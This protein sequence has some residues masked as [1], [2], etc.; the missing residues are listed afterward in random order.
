MVRV[1]IID[2][3][4]T[5]TETDR[6]GES[7]HANDFSQKIS[8]DTDVYIRIPD[9]KPKLLFSYRRK[10]I[11]DAKSWSD[12]LRQCF[13]TPILT[14]DRRFIASGN[15]GKRVTV[16]SG[17]IGFY[18]RLTPQQKKILGVNMAG[19][20]TAFTRHFHEAW[21]STCVPF[22]Q[23]VSS[24]YRKHCP[25]Y[26]KIQERFIQKI[27]RELRIQG[28]V[29]TTATVNQD[30]ATS[31]HRDRGDFPDGMSCLVVLGNGFKGGFLAFP[32]RNVLVKMR[33]GDM[34]MM[35]SHEPHGNTELNVQ[36]DGKR[37]SLVC[38][39]RTDL[40]LCHTKVET[41]NG[42]VFYTPSRGS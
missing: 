29:F 26:Y 12:R 15:R 36:K 34:I 25:S 1:M 4:E 35:D 7:L 8:K 13:V 38:Y 14:S 28:T 40:Q 30:W 16:R 2:E 17:V 21:V 42:E 31:V 10:A 11:P 22:F 20:A 32:R 18:D 5:E 3:N 37:L 39:V 9:A 6:I 27:E 23:L 41:E 19:R 33:H 24:L